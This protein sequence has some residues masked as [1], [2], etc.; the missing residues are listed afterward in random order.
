[1]LPASRKPPYA[2]FTLGVVMFLMASGVVPNVQAALIGGLLMGLFR[3]I[4]LDQAYRAIQWRGYPAE[5]ATA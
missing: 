1:V 2:T 5:R 3:C 4:D